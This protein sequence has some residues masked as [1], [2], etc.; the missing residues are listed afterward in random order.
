[1]AWLGVSSEPGVDVAAVDRF[2]CKLASQALTARA[3]SRGSRESAV[4]HAASE[5]LH[6]K[7][8]H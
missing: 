1:M 5:H 8:V 7:A 3:K 2:V 4:W 6:L